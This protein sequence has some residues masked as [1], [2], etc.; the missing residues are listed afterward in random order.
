VK[1]KQPFAKP[2]LTQRP[3]PPKVGPRQCQH[4]Y[5]ILDTNFVIENDLVSKKF[6]FYCTKCTNII[7]KKVEW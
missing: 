1:I 7:T 6:A 4:E 2:S 5:K 3:E